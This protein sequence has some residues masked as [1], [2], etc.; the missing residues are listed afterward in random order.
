MRKTGLFGELKE[1]IAKMFWLH[2]D[3]LNMKDPLRSGLLF[4]FSCTL[5]LKTL[6]VIFV[7]AT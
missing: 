4:S 1:K 2:S 7:I 6:M 5:H 3:L